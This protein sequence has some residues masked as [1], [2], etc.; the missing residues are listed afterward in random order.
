MKRYAAETGSAW[1]AVLVDPLARRDIYT[2]L[3]TGPEMIAALFR[4]ARTGEIDHTAATVAASEFR[5]DWQT[6]YLI[7]ELTITVAELAMSLA[8]RYGLRGYDSVHLAAAISLHQRRQAGGLPSL[9]FVSADT[10]QRTA[11]LREGLAVDNPN[12]HP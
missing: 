2:V 8:E 9:T 7:V 5:L 3:L 4:K 11:A 1:V 12:D 6:Q 10:A